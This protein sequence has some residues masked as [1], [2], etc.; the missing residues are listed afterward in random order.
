M[1]GKLKLWE[2]FKIV[3]EGGVV[4]DKDGGQFSFIRSIIAGIED[5]ESFFKEIP[6]TEAEKVAKEMLS[7][8]KNMGIAFAYDIMDTTTPIGVVF[9]LLS[10]K[11]WRKV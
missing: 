8:W 3:E 2:A 9:K 4:Y 1:T 7:D 10:E 5:G 11:G 6:I